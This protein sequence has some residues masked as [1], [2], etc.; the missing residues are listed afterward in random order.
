MSKCILTDKSAFLFPSSAA[1]VAYVRLNLKEIHTNAMS[2]A[3]TNGKIF[4]L[5]TSLTVCYKFPFV[6][7]I[8]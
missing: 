2:L 5:V 6:N 7:G 8:I 3:E 1:S 4:P